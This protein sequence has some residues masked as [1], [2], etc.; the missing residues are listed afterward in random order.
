MSAGFM[1]LTIAMMTDLGLNRPGRQE[2]GGLSDVERWALNDH[3]QTDLKR[4]LDERRAYLYCYFLTST[5]VS[6]S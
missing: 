5:Y 1:Q 6:H 3:T 2:E 4:T